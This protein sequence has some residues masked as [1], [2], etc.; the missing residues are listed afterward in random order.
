MNVRVLTNLLVI[1]TGVMLLGGVVMIS[2]AA[3]PLAEQAQIQELLRNAREDLE[4]GNFQ[5]AMQNLTAAEKAAPN[6]PDIRKALA[7]AYLAN[8]QPLQALQELKKAVEIAPNDYDINEAYGDALEDLESPQAALAFYSEMTTKFPSQLA[9]R[10]RAAEVHEE[11][12][13]P[14]LAEK[15]W[16][17]ATKTDKDDD[18]AWVRWGQLLAATGDL[19]GAQKVFQKGIEQLP[20]SALLHFN[21]GALL[22]VVGKEKEALQELRTA[23]QLDGEFKQLLDQIGIVVTA[24]ATKITP[25]HVVTLRENAD[26]A[27]YVPSVL[28]KAVLARLVI[29]Q[30][31][32]LSLLSTPLAKRLKVDTIKTPPASFKK[33]SAPDHKPTCTLKSVKV[34]TVTVIDLPATV[35]NPAATERN[36]PKDGLLGMNYLDHF[37]YHID[38]HHQQLILVTR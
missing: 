27:F 8:N 5:G 12:G 2:F 36:T 16:E 32:A 31:V 22:S 25:V 4:D 29:D 11:M 1:G 20:G 9:P 33:A 19:E 37:K 38:G 6:R 14:K 17:E 34:S 30:N 13:Q 24:D 26:G 18:T 3:R 23:E 28:D 10:A 15:L 21:L 7:E 35:F